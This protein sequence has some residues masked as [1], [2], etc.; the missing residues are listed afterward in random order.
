MAWYVRLYSLSIKEKTAV[1]PMCPLFR[2]STVTVVTVFQLLL[3]E[4]IIIMHFISSPG[5]L[6]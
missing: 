1:V 4:D 5:L 3:C 6:S 2:G